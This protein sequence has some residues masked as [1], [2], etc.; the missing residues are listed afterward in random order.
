MVKEQS[1]G[2]KTIGIVFT[3]IEGCIEFMSTLMDCMS[4]LKTVILDIYQRILQH[5]RS[6]KNS[7][8]E[9]YKTIKTLVEFFLE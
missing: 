2:K 7:L 8:V 1:V 9:L 3:V 4:H 5:I 6:F